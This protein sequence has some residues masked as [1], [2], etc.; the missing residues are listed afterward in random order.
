[1]ERRSGGSDLS[2]RDTI[3][4]EISNV[5]SKLN[6]KK[7]LIKSVNLSVLPDKGA[8]LI[9]KI[10]ELET[11]LTNLKLEAESNSRTKNSKKK[12]NVFVDSSSTAGSSS[13]QTEQ[14]SPASDEIVEKSTIVGNHKNIGKTDGSKD[15][16]L[17]SVNEKNVTVK[18]SNSKSISNETDQSNSSSSKKDSKSSFID[19]QNNNGKAHS[20]RNQILSFSRGKNESTSKSVSKDLL[21]QSLARCPAPDKPV[22][23]HRFEA[24]LASFDQLSKSAPKLDDSLKDLVN[25]P[26]F[27]GWRETKPISKIQLIEAK[28]LFELSASQKLQQDL[29]TSSYPRTLTSEETV[30]K[31]HHSLCVYPDDAVDL[32]E[33]KSL[34]TPLLKH[35]IK[36]FSWLVWRESQM[37][38]GGILADDMGLGKTLT[39]ISL[40][41][42][43]KEEN[44]YLAENSNCSTHA[45][46]IVCLASIIHQWNEEISKHCKINSLQV[47][48]YHGSKRE[49]DIEDMKGYDVVLTTYNILLSERKALIK[50][51]IPTGLFQLKWERVILD[52]AHTIKNYKSQTA[53]AVF[54]LSSC[55]KWCVTGTPIHNEFKDMYSLVK[56][57]Q[58][59]PFDDEKK[60]KRL[61]ND[62]TISSDRRRDL[63][64]K[65]ILLR[66]TKGDSDKT[67]NLLIKMVKKSVNVCNIEL[68]EVE[69]VVYD[70]L[71]SQVKEVLSKLF[72]KAAK[73]LNASN[74]LLVLLLRL[75]QC[76]CHISLLR[77]K[78]EDLETSSDDSVQELSLNLS[79]L[80]IEEKCNVPSIGSE[81][82]LDLSLSELINDD[83]CDRMV[84]SVKL[85]KLYEMLDKIAEESNNKDKS[86]IVSQWVS[87]LEIVGYHLREKGIEYHMIAGN[88]KAEDRQ[89]ASEDF[90]YNDDGCKIMLLSL[91]AGGVGLNLVGGNH[92]FLLD[93]HWNP[94][95]ERQACDRIHRVGQT[96]DVFIY[97]FVCKKTIEEKIL[98][99]QEGKSALADDVLHGAKKGRGLRTA[100][101]DIVKENEN[102]E[103]YYKIQG[104]TP[105]EEWESFMK[106][107]RETLPATFRITGTGGQAKALLSIIKGKYFQDLMKIKDVTDSSYKP[108]SLP[109]YPGNLAWQMQLSRVAIR[110]SEGHRQLHNFL[111][112]ET[113]T[114]NI[115]R[116]ETVSMIPPLLLNVEPHHKV[117]DMCAAPGSKTAQLIEF[118]HKDENKIPDGLIVANDVDNKR[119]YMLVHQAKRLNSPCLL[120]TNNDAANYPNIKIKEEGK[121]VNLKFDR[122]LCDVP[123]SGDGTLRKTSEI[124]TKWNPAT[125]NNLHGLQLRI[126]RRG[127]ELLTDG[128]RIVYSTCSLNPVENEAVISTILQDAK[129]SVELLDVRSSLPG[130]K[131]NPGLYEW[132]ITNKELEVFSKFDEVPEKNLT[133]VRPHMFP[134]STEVAKELHLEHCIRIL[135]HHQDTGGFFVAVLQKNGKLPWLKDTDNVV[136]NP[137]RPPPKKRK[138]WGYKE[139]PFIFLKDVE[140]LWPELKEF[141]KLN[142]DFP[143]SQFLSRRS[144]G[145]MR[146]IYFTSKI[147]KNIIEEN[148]DNIKVINTGVR[149][150]SRSENKD[151]MCKYRL[152][153]EG[154]STIFPYMGDRKLD[155][156][157]DDLIVLL[158][159]EYPV[160][161]LFSQETQE[162]LPKIESGCLV[163]CY[164]GN[165]GAEDEFKVQLCGWKANQTLRCYI[166]K[167]GRAHYL[168]IIGV[169]VSEF[170]MREKKKF[171][172]KDESE[173][174]VGGNPEEND[175]ADDL[176]DEINLNGASIKNT[177]EELTVES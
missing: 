86:V 137:D 172:I 12:K 96:K 119:C 68:S 117:L 48:L 51:K 102:F 88:T 168:R 174:A 17:T 166:P 148:N 79:A 26:S 131:S 98:Q 122:I 134:P 170:E 73:N 141:Y 65:S 31:L 135:P 18:P 111:V 132:K 90:N 158:S 173:E 138:I 39:M 147:V 156:N 81:S 151:T 49:K 52:E 157:R 41:L 45:T 67:G 19:K 24:E 66:R 165:I 144:E 121:I 176:P 115:S 72:N 92:M 160:H 100:Y 177:S 94:A 62:D 6:E 57:L 5:S 104:I 14:F 155:L 164:T 83:L 77:K 21:K 78:T 143:T 37:P 40:I 95:L 123:C 162:K 7:T 171:K 20:D 36:G 145:K 103:K 85:Q 43:Q 60:W 44:N 32:K 169:D 127:L 22:F 63:L 27:K 38:S 154:V 13:K 126:L 139:D 107:M 112:S 69:R 80:N 53:E 70:E 161:T 8:R 15:F 91:K 54:S 108:F 25:S 97:K 146:K 128:G 140:D 61:I 46:L 59:S 35:Q 30:K 129:G 118:L 74:T 163:L 167:K 116:Q 33:P 42:K 29:F 89:I 110:S 58:F 125:A 106:T 120:I 28:P 76:C 130:L 1:M 55:R 142:E 11:Q 87:L 152:T 101:K 56:F 3:D 159:H 99:L 105:S 23:A 149:F 34:K 2:P 113:D 4:F 50:K 9:K 150:L 133:H 109:W 47:L 82:N 64:V 114:G 10:E 93:L 153:Q 136:E 84:K 16:I 75:Q 175:S 71:D 124:W